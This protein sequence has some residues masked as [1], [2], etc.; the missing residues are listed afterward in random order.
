MMM[1]PENTTP[2]LA[3]A[4]DGG[5][6][7]GNGT[8]KRVVDWE[9]AKIQ[10]LFSLPMILTNLAYYAIPLV[11]V[12]FAGHLG[13]VELAAANL[14]N[15][16]ATVTGFSFMEINIPKIEY[17]KS[18]HHLHWFFIIT[19]VISPTTS[20]ASSSTPPPPPV[21]APP[22]STTQLHH[23]QLTKSEKP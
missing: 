2:L 21:P 14:A 4:A 20:K 19:G 10:I 1:T 3:K 17:T 11:S 9:E 6:R 5:G 23:S 13:E 8:W 22:H 16:W 15:S 18:N 7:G 12:M